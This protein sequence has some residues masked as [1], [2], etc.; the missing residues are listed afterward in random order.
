MVPVRRHPLRRPHHTEF[1]AS[2]AVKWRSCYGVCPRLYCAREKLGE[3]SKI[4]CRGGSPI[5]SELARRPRAERGFHITPGILMQTPGLGENPLDG[6]PKEVYPFHQKGS[7]PFTPKRYTPFDQ[8]GLP[9]SPQRGIPLSIKGV[10][11]FN[12]KGYTSLGPPPRGFSLP[13]KG[14]TRKDRRL[15]HRQRQARCAIGPSTQRQYIP[16]APR[17]RWW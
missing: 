4:S 16:D 2:L 17:R 15:S 12:A 6:G 1:R 7:I 14:S 5:F 3:P 11:P 8:R 10:D 13:S 9:L